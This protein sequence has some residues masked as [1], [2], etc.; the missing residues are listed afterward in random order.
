MDSFMADVTDL[1]DVKVGDEVIIWDN[2][3]IMLED[4]SD[5]CGTISYEILCTIG[6][7]VP[8]KFV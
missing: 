2:E 3:N 8:R 4:L 6:G 5:K 7:R 1:P